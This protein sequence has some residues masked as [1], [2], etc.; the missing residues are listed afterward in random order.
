MAPM[1][2]GRADEIQSPE[3]ASSVA[4]SGPAPKRPWFKKKRFVIPIA[5]VAIGVIYSAGSGGSGQEAAGTATGQ[6]AASGNG[7]PDQPSEQKL[8]GLGTPV[9]DGQFEF[10]AS[11][12]TCGIK[13]VGDEF[14]NEKAQGQFCILDVTAKNIGDQPQT[15][16]TDNQDAFS[17]ST[18]Y[19]SNS[20]AAIYHATEK[21]LDSSNWIKEINPGNQLKAAVVFDVP[22]DK[23]I[24][25]VKLHDSAFSGGVEISVR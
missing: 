14:L 15:F 2:R 19:S 24:D 10:V 11:K 18:K 1:P 6:T 20:S 5:V 12:M 17:G 4:P 23:T 7:N 8:P 22:A 3:P 25:K 13:Q 9:R 21:G 16:F